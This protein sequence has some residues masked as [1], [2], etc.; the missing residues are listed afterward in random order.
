[1]AHF[2]KANSLVD[3]EARKRGAAVYLMNREHPFFFSY[4]FSLLVPGA[5]P[6]GIMT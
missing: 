6:E 2:I 3:R 4:V 1:V 5:V